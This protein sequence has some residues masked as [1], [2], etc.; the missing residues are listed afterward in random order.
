MVWVHH[1]RLITVWL[2]A[3]LA[4]ALEDYVAKTGETKSEVVRKALRE[5]LRNRG[6]SLV[7][8]TLEYSSRQVYTRKVASE[9]EVVVV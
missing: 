5:Y 7:Y 2:D 6:Y 8:D 3:E 9:V 1:P 4:T